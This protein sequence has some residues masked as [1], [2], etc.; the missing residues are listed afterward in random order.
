MKFVETSMY[1]RCLN[2]YSFYG[3]FLVVILTK[4]FSVLCKCCTMEAIIPSH[5]LVQLQHFDKLSGSVTTLGSPFF[6]T[7]VAIVFSLR[8]VSNERKENRLIFQI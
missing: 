3:Y 2:L 8:I 1:I 6:Q 5:T 7:F 4:N